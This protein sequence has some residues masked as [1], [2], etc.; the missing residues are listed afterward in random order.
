M[1]T[2]EHQLDASREPASENGMTPDIAVVIPVKDEAGNI[3]ALLDEIGRELATLRFEV[4]CVD[5][6]S[7]DATPQEL[8]EARERFDWLTVVRHRTSCGQSTATLSGVRAARADWVVTMDGDGQNPPGEI[9]KLVTA[10][11]MAADDIAMVAGQREKRHDSW[12]RRLS[13]RIANG[14][15]QKLLNDGIRDTG[16]SLKLFRRQTF[17]ELPYF[18][19][20][21]RFLPALVQRHGGKVITAPVAHRARMH[22][23]SKYGFHNRLWPGIVDL[24]GVLWLKRRTR[25]PKIE[26][27]E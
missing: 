22:G 27:T 25:L 16:C 15:R 1:T 11:D 24:A 7:T 5:D 9:L 21:H 17:L 12:F 3:G 23:E 4:V 13:S 18:D 8:A 6:G 20:M 19:H 26:K 10:R 2:A 14:V